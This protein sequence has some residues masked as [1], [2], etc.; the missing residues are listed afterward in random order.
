MTRIERRSLIILVILVLEVEILGG[1]AIPVVG[2]PYD[3]PESPKKS[4]KLKPWG[5]PLLI[6]LNWP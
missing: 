2:G 1:K 6:G 5:K 4:S 3:T